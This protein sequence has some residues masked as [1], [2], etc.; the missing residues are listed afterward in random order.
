M[1]DRICLR[2]VFSSLPHLH[3]LS[4]VLAPSI[5]G[6]EQKKRPPAPTSPMATNNAASNGAA[7][8]DPKTSYENAKKD[9]I[10]ALQRKRQLD[11]QLV[12]PRLAQSWTI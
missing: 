9:L 1:I 5:R 2:P 7:F 3:L 4:T 10:A 11:K 6:G 12:R 8:D